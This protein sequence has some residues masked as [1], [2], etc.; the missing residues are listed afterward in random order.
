MAAHCATCCPAQ[1]MKERRLFRLF[2]ALSRFTGFPDL[3]EGQRIGAPRCGLPGGNAA[4]RHAIWPKI[5][6]GNGGVNPPIPRRTPVCWREPRKKD[7]TAT[8]PTQVGDKRPVGGLYS[9]IHSGGSIPQT[10]PAKCRGVGGAAC[11]T[12]GTSAGRPRTLAP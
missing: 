7:G 6:W 1:M 5:P 12:G 3:R 2:S 10:T 8:Q 9:P 11:D 4:S